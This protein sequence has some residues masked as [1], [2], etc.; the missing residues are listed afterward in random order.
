MLINPLISCS[1]RLPIYILIIGTFFPNHATLMLMLIYF[2]GIALAVIMAKIFRRHLIKGEDTPFVMELPPYRMPTLKSTLQHMWDKARS[3][4]KKM[5]GIILIASVIIWFL[6]YFPRTAPDAAEYD[7]QRDNVEA[8]YKVAFDKLAE[9][10]LSEAE[11]IEAVTYNQYKLDVANLQMEMDHEIRH[12]DRLEEVSRQ[13]NSYI[14][15]VGVFFEPI[16]KPLV[17]NW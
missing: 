4:L 16:F 13:R 7:L 14:G 10:E 12:I 11:D 1:A 5:G 3:Y 15:R 8:E 2:I 17:F 6:G 9:A